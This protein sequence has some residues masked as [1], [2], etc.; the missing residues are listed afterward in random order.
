MRR[1]HAVPRRLP[2]RRA[3]RRRTCSTR[4]GASS[5][6]TIELEGPIPLEQRAVDRRRTF[7][8]DICQEV[9]PWNRAGRSTADPAWQPRPRDGA[10]AAE[11]WRRT[12]QELHGMVEGQRDDAHLAGSPAP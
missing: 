2:D 5:Y 7:G 12:D 4:P 11:L 1:V 9:C 10:R 6:L 3:G 8:C